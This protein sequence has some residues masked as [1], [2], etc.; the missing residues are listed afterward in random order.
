MPY[1]GHPTPN[2]PDFE[3]GFIC[4]PI[5]VPDLP[6]LWVN[7]YGQISEMT[8]AKYWKQ[9]GTMTPE[10]AAMYW[11][12]ALALTDL[13]DDCINTES[14]N[15]LEYPT[16]NTDIITF[17]PID[18]Y[19]NPNGIPSGFIFPPF[20]RYGA[21]LPE[22]IP[23]IFQDWLDTYLEDTTGYEPNDILTLAGSFPF[24]ANWFNGLFGNLPRFTVTVEGKGRVLLHL[25]QVPLGGRALITVDLELDISDIISG[26]ITEN[27]KM[28]ELERD[29]LSV[30]SEK[31]FDHIEEIVLNTDGTHI[32]YVTY[33]PVIDADEI[34]LKYGGGIRSVEWCAESDVTLPIDCDYIK[35]CFDANPDNVAL[36]NITV[37]AMEGTTQQFLDELDAL[38]D[39]TNPNS[40]NPAIPTIA[41]N[42]VE[43]DALCWTIETWLNLYAHAKTVKIKQASVLSQGWSAIQ[44]AIVVAYGVLN[45]V[46]GFILPDDLFSCFVDNDTAL[47]ALANAVAMDEVKCSLYNDLSGI[48]L[49]EG[50]LEGAINAAVAS[51]TGTA[52][53]I[54]CLLDNDYSLAHALNFFFL[55]GRALDNSLA[56]DCSG[57][58]TSEMYIEYDFTVSNHG[59]TSADGTWTNGVGWT[60]NVTGSGNPHQAAMTIV[61]T[62]SGSLPI[63]WAGGFIYDAWRNCGINS[64]RWDIE[65]DAVNVGFGTIGNITS[66]DGVKQVWT[67]NNASPYQAVEFDT[68]KFGGVAKCCNCGNGKFIIKKAR[69][70]LSPASPVTGVNTV[71]FPEGLGANGSASNTFWNV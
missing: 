1:S 7:L 13:D 69:I 38:Y 29:E 61:K 68:V 24:T 67:R 18:P 46:F 2:N 51:L 66:A 8:F 39:D 10:Q 4:K 31:D 15:C 33:L 34:P 55:Y 6:E 23:D 20:V 56:G 3:M 40:I 47:A 5:F 9:S 30:P 64:H 65:K 63:G 54:A 25:L 59:F 71:V 11:A 44:E 45:N 58:I 32:I 60:A 41:P 21:L 28:I 50:S 19:A 12:R 14:N 70:W 48:A 27:Y 37:V 42:A 49:L 16:N 17:S 52:Q 57:C 22:F 53:D 35:D 43:K 26:V 62:F 36:N